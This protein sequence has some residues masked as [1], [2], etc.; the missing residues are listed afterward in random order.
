MRT[1]EFDL[2]AVFAGQIS[3]ADMTG[4]LQH[5]DLYGI[6]DELFNDLEAILDVVTDAAVLFVPRDL[7]ASDHSEQGWTMSHIIA[8]LTATLEEAAAT[9][10]MLARGVQVEQRLRYETPWQ[11]LSTFQMVKARLQESHRLSRVFLDAW[12]DEPHLHV[13]M[14]LLPVLGPMDAISRYVLG[15]AHGQGHLDQLR[16]ARRQYLSSVDR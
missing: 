4:G 6:T 3:Y 10:A 12:P 9:A 5:A 2:E 15:I 11:Q 13:T 16:E 1:M 7:E 14:M 8:H